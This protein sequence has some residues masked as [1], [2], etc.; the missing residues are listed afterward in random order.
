MAMLAEIGENAR[1]LALLFETLESALKVFVVVNYDFRQNLR[2]RFV[3]PFF[4]C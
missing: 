2:P 1:F 4:A 3:A